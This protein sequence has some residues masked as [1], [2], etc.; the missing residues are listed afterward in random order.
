MPSAK[1]EPTPIAVD[2]E[3]VAEAVLK[4][5]EAVRTMRGKVRDKLIVLMLNDQTGL[6]KRD[7]QRLLDA[8]PELAR[9]YLKR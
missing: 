2:L 1:N 3:L 8:I 4:L 5:E 6:P 9:T 7:I